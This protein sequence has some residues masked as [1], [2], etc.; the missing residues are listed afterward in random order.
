M[1]CHHQKGLKKMPI[2]LHLT[3]RPA[4]SVPSWNPNWHCASPLWRVNRLTTKGMNP[5][6]QSTGCLGTM[7]CICYN[8]QC[9]TS[10]KKYTERVTNFFNG[11]INEE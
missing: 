8:W 3:L 4:A 10:E 5:A 11:E 7:K 9:L 6:L 1:I 2:Q